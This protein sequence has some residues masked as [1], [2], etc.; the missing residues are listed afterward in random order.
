MGSRVT[1]DTGL[2]ARRTAFMHRLQARLAG[3]ARPAA[4]FAMPPEPRTIGLAARGHHL[5]AGR[6]LF[7]GTL[8]DAPGSSP[9]APIAPDPGFAAEAQGFGWLDDLAAVGDRVAQAR[10]Q[11]WTRD[12]IARFGR[13]QGPGWTPDLTG[14]RLLRWTNHA[15]WLLEGCDSAETRAV[16]RVLT[17]QVVFLSRRWPAA[18]PGLPRFEALAGLICAGL[19]LEGQARRIQPAR[20][21][22]AQDCARQ[23]ER[24][25][26]IPS[27]NPKDLLEIFTLLVWTEQA[28]AEDGQR[29]SPEHRA[30]IERIAPAL[31]SL[32]HA[33]G[34]LA[35]FHG[36]GRGLDGRLDA[37]LAGSGTRAVP[38]AGLVMGYA[39]LSGGRTSVIV[40][41]ASPPDGAAAATAH[42][43]TLAFELTSGR[44]PLIVSCGSGV[45]FG[46]DWRRAG[47]AT[48]SHST[49][50]L[51]GFSSSRFS[52]RGAVGEG[53]GRGTG[54]GG[55]PGETLSDRAKVSQAWL[56]E[57]AGVQSLATA[58]EGWVRTHGLTHARQL[59]LTVDGR[60]LRGED[61]LGAFSPAETRRFEQVQLR[62]GGIR[63]ALRFHLHPDVGVLPD[64]DGSSLAL[65]LK[66]GEVWRLGHD[67][68]ADLTVEPS[69]YLE[70]G[71]LQP[72]PSRQ[73]V[74]S[75]TMQGSA[76]QI[77]WT[78]AKTQDTPL[79]I[80]DLGRDDPSAPDAE[81]WGQP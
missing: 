56:T 45:P 37:A 14:R 75:A 32:R 80:R 9:F 7:A 36:G 33:D 5:I 42:A 50:S 44:R 26:G 25:G 19:A 62:S 71:R 23:I 54:G 22:L 67:G 11:D 31:R 21:A 53:T 29:P 43:S 12:W 65:F 61:I 38:A 6:F 57:G 2:T 8:V 10:A 35:R 17:R 51:E 66:S 68:A 74:L 34:G 40:D 16:L 79:A 39:R 55:G 58:H 1:E 78:L 49:L 4:G 20:E 59:H 63:F 76:V 46:P 18:S 13:G 77:D 27:R 30:A 15:L 70:K 3:W 47:R 72:R 41:A 64:E 81:P 73:V 69:V 52:T 48:A 60:T 24:D 28:L